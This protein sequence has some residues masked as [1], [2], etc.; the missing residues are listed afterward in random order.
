MDPGRKQKQQQSSTI[1]IEYKNEKKKILIYI[2]SFNSCSKSNI[3]IRRQKV[4]NLYGLYMNQGSHELWKSW[5]IQKKSS[6]H[7]KIMEFEKA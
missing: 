4:V 6:M 5:K 3:I 7:G 2:N 1:V